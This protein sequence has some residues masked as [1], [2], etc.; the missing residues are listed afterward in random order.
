MG[1]RLGRRKS[2]LLLVEKGNARL[3]G[4][5]PAHRGGEEGPVGSHPCIGIVFLPSCF[6]F[7]SVGFSL[8]FSRTGFEC[9]CGPCLMSSFFFLFFSCFLS[10]P[11]RNPPPVVGM[12]GTE[13]DG[14]PF[15]RFFT[16]GLVENSNPKPGC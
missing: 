9:V 6:V 15:R 8:V 12:G 10:H 14:P 2:K 13:K 3:N 16:A 1:W 11:R 7:C 4:A 5:G